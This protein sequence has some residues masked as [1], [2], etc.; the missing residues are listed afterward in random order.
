MEEIMI[1]Y[2]K[3][4][5]AA[6]DGQ[7]VTLMVGGVGFEMMMPND[8]ETLFTIGEEAAIY[9]Y[10][11]VRENEIGLY[12]FSSALEKKL[13]NVLIG[14]SGIGPKSAM[15][16]LGVSSP[17]GIITAI[18]TGDEKL[19]SSLPGIGKKTAARLILELGEKIAKEFPLITQD[20]PAPVQKKAAQQPSAIENDLTDALIALGYRAHEIK[21]MQE[22]TDVLEETDVNAALKKALQY[23]ARG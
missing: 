8:G 20:A 23:F 6:S 4:T 2:L 7:I 9:T 16:M 5:V 19:L 1:G 11:H 14:V 22:A 12:G 13:F 10:M 15:Q 3:G 21:E 18:T 17:Q